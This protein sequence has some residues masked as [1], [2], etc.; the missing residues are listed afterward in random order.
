MGDLIK[1]L[2]E[3][4][5]LDDL[6]FRVQSIS[7][8]G[9]CTVLAYKDARVDM[10][11]LDAVCGELWQRDHKFI[12]N[13]LY[14]GIGIKIENEWVWRWDVG[15]ESNT[16]A[17]KGQASD[18]FKRAGF[19]WGIGRELYSLPRI[20]LQLKP[21]EFTVNGNKGKQSFGFHLDK[22]VWAFF[23]V[24][25]EKHLGARDET[26]AIRFDSRKE[27]NKIGGAA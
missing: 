5:S 26:G 8:K 27:W 17:T 14:C 25:G 18:S 10:D 12:N 11:R 9:W 24:D 23:E 6:S 3:P 2:S 19:N 13:T 20:F 21:S 7:A 4:L 16:E 15:T 1:K 22:W